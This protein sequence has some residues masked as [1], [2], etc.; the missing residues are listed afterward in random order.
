MRQAP[1]IVHNDKVY[2]DDLLR[3]R[4]NGIDKI[5]HENL[6]SKIQNHLKEARKTYKKTKKS[7]G[8][9]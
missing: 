3:F 2:S 9:Q 8:I 5:C 4:L 6:K 7:K 1:K